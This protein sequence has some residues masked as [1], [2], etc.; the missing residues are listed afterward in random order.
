MHLQEYTLFDLDLGTK[1]THNIAKYP[2]HH[3]TYVPSKLF[4]VATSKM[5]LQKNTLI[6]LSP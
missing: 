3:V 4:E 1:A 5:Q 2:L 6:D